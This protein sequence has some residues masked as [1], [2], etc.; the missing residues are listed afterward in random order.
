M[1]ITSAILTITSAKKTTMTHFLCATIDQCGNAVKVQD[2]WL[3]YG[4]MLIP[5]Q[6][7]FFLYSGAVITEGLM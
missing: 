3:V 5:R 2:V 7:R 4:L 6:R 1:A